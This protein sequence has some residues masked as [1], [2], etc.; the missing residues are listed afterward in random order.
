[1]GKNN[2][3]NPQIKYTARTQSVPETLI[4][5]EKN[6]VYSPKTLSRTSTKK[7]EQSQQHSWFQTN[8]YR[9]LKE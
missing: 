7:N 2:N 5:E 8:I 6:A 3:P 9:I 1:M 4:Q